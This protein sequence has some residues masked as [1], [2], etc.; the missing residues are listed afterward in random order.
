MLADDARRSVKP[1][2]HGAR[3]ARHGE[4]GA[5]VLPRA[6]TRGLMSAHR[7]Q[8]HPCAAANQLSDTPLLEQSSM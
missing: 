6:F 7:H 4:Q 5:H 2:G 1:V 8:C 3:F